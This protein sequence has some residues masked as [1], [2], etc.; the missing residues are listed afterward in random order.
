[1]QDNTPGQ[2]PM[3]TYFGVGRDTYY[4]IDLST[5]KILSVHYDVD[6]GLADLNAHLP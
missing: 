2:T 6:S 5:M 4:V 1:V 3:E